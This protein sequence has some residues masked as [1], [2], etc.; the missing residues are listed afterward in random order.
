MLPT[1]R[2]M[3][4]QEKV[5]GSWE[6]ALSDVHAFAIA[7]CRLVWELIVDGVVDQDPILLKAVVGIP[8]AKSHAI[9]LRVK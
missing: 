3:I 5:V 9:M 2:M 8:P 4:I 6:R 7:A 1:P